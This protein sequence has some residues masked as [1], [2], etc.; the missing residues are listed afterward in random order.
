MD[1]ETEKLWV[2][3]AK[4]EKQVTELLVVID[5]AQAALRRAD[6]VLSDEDKKHVIN[7]SLNG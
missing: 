4:L 6:A 3:L 5:T 1:P 7:P 2:Q